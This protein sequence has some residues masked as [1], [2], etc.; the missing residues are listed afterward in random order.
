LHL[1]QDDITV[2]DWVGKF[3]QRTCFLAKTLYSVF[4][5]YTFWKRFL[6]A[7]STLGDQFQMK[8]QGSYLVRSYGSANAKWL[9]AVLMNYMVLAGKLCHL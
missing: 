2:L 8:K 7:H 5:D 3:T 4:A 6:V 9:H 1:F